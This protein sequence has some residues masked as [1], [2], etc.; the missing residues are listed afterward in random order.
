MT[1]ERLHVVGIGNA[2]V[3][4]MAYVDDAFLDA[5][6]LP[7]GAMTLV[8]YDRSQTLYQAMGACAE[9][10]GGSVANSLAGF[11]SF[12]GRS[13]FIGKVADDAL[14]DIFRADAHQVGVQFVTSPSTAGHRTASCLVMVTPDAQ[15]TMQTY[16]GVAGDIR[17]EDIDDS[18]VAS[19]EV[20]YIEG[21]LW[22]EPET[23]ASLRKAIRIAR[24]NG[25]KV[26]FSLSDL[27]CVDR[28]REEFL[29]LIS[30]HL[31]IVFA[32]EQEVMA[33]Y[34]TEDFD[35]AVRAIRGQCEIAALTR[36]AD[37][38][39]LVTPDEAI[40]VPAEK[41]ANVV[42][43]TGAGDLYAAGL[44][45][46]LTHGFPLAEAGALGGK[47]AGQIITHLGARALK[48]LSDILA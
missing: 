36:S 44:L 34:Q 7:K 35:E 38:S 33:L 23:I 26:A 6:G 14:G 19:G 1:D 25:R 3:D 12:G 21:Y 48:P 20:L 28:H 11:S 29:E 2:I 46:G 13:A 16:L 41:V 39:V 32:N 10:S 22:D 17:Q 8:D 43:T 45:Y 30:E 31:D 42:D 40:V 4:V 15:R 18:L 27:F 37:G 47:A 9:C 5:H 24:E